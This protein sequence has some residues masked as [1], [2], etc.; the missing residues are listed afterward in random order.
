MARFAD[1]RIEIKRGLSWTGFERFLDEKDERV[2]PRV[3]YL[4]GVLE[5]VTPSYGHEKHGS[6]I[7]A[8]VITYGVERG[9]DMSSYRSWLLKDEVKKAGAEPDECFVIGDEA[10]GPAQRPDIV[11]EVQWSRRG[12]NKLEVYRRLRVPEV[13]FWEKGTLT[14][15]VRNRRTFRM[16]DRSA[17]LPGLDIPHMLS[18]LDRTNLTQ[19]IRD[20]R[21]SL[22][23]VD[24]DPPVDEDV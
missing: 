22:A 24:C 4:D 8:L 2:V 20:Y 18:F 11:V 14:I 12:V 6:W 7:G 21:A 5:L 9:I 1:D 16:V 10:T 13:W 15:Y 3:C 17:A 23:K 19:A